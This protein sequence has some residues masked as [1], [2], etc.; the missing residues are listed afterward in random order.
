MSVDDVKWAVP[1]EVTEQSPKS[2]HVANGDGT[3]DSHALA[4]KLGPL[5]PQSFKPAL[6]LN[7]GTKVRIYEVNLVISF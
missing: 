7:V 2:R 1:P 6:K 4:A 5:G 3:T